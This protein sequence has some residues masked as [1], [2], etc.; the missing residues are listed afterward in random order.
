MDNR[1]KIAAAAVV[2]IGLGIGALVFAGVL[3]APTAAERGQARTLTA[4]AQ[5]AYDSGDQDAAL[6]ALDQA[7]ELANEDEALRLRASIY[8]AR[9]NYDGALSDISRVIGRGSAG[10]GDYSLRCWLRARGDN[11]D[12]ARRDCDRAIEMDSGLASGFGNRGLVGLRQ[13]RNI[14]AWEDFNTAL[15][16]GGSDQWVAW[17]LFGRGLASSGRGEPAVA[18]QDMQTA[19]I[20][21]PGVAAQYAEFGL[22]REE[23]RQ[24]DDAT[25]AAA[26]DPRSLI[27]LQ[28]YLYVY[29]DGAHAAEARVQIAE[30]YAWIAEDQAAGRQTVPGFSLAQ[31]RGTAGPE[32]SFGAIGLSRSRWRVAF[33]TDYADPVEAER[34]AAAACNASGVRDCEAY[35][36]RNVCAAMAISPNDRRVGMAWAHGEDDAVRTSIQHC[37]ARGG[38]ACVPVHSQCTP[39]PPEDAATPATQ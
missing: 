38:Q 28:Q 21:N 7:V 16:V 6:Q 20:S 32:D 34:A 27:S 17:R 14:E 25:F 36:F 2:I 5:T 12:G 18:R 30:I 11:L 9:A 35:A 37:R 13:G 39:T 26:M 22:G 24:F 10:P 29:P 4:Q 33:V 15:R 1:L 31:D 3:N 23:V 19:L 8:V